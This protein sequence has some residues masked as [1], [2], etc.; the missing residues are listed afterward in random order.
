[1]IAKPCSYSYD[2]FEEEARKK[3]LERLRHQ[4]STFVEIERTLW[5]GMGITSGQSVID[6]GCGTGFITNE[7]SKQVSPSRVVGIDISR[8]L[9]QECTKSSHADCSAFSNSKQTLNPSFKEGSVYDI[10]F[11]AESFDVAYARLIFQHL[12]EPVRALES[13]LRVL[14]P[15]GVV[16]IV[17]VDKGWSGL[18]PEPDTSV[19][20]DQAIIREHLSQGGD[21]WVGRKLSYYL[22]TSGFKQVRTTVSLVDS[23]RVGLESFFSC[24]SF[25]DSHQSEQNQLLGLQRRARVDAQLLLE[26]PDA[27]AGFGLFVATGEK[28]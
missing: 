16:C 21:P 14:K 20:L 23:H 9:L 27:W 19:E 5:P 13:I 6:I 4:A 2:T 8:S 10:P 18:C 11:P 26:N 3:E 17:D 25:G 1:M 12:A 22:S 24:L 7:L 28:A 15:G